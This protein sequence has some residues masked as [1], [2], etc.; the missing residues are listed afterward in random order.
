MT[1]LAVYIMI[2]FSQSPV[3]VLDFDG[4]VTEKDIGDE[5]CD[6]FAPPEWRD[7]DA[8][9]VRHEISLPEAQRRMW[10]LAR[11]ERADAVAH[12]LAVGR[13]R[14]GLDRLLDTASR[15][16]C[17]LWLASGGFDFYIEAILGSRLERFSRRYYNATRFIDGRIA[18]EFPHEAIACSRCAVC[19]GNV[20]DAARATGRPVVFIGDGS[21]D[22]CAIGRADQVFAVRGSLLARTCVERGAEY[23]GF[24]GFDEITERLSS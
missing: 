24:D 4:T 13:L 5:V 16:G 15:H 7:V 11:A 23:I 18:V 17:D 21:S 8:A 19:K 9:W 14:P 20:C 12:A 3:I 10:A 6:R 1:I 22:R 2:V